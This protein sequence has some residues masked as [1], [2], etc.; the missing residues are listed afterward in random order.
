MDIAGATRT[1]TAPFDLSYS[2]AIRTLWRALMGDVS[3]SELPASGP[4]ILKVE[5]HIRKRAGF[6]TF[7]IAVIAPSE[8]PFPLMLVIAGVVGIAII[9][10]FLYRRKRK[11]G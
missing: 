6:S 10:A 2:G 5:T 1:V 8:K 3:P 9:V 11:F 7:A 4:A